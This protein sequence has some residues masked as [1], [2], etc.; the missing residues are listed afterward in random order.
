MIKKHDSA[1]TS[2]KFLLPFFL[3]GYSFLLFCIVWNHHSSYYYAVEDYFAPFFLIPL[4]SGL[5]LGATLVHKLSQRISAKKSYQ[6]LAILSLVIGLLGQFVPALLEQLNQSSRDEARAF[7]QLL[8]LSLCLTP[9]MLLYGAFVSIALRAIHGLPKIRQRSIQALSSASAGALIGV[10]SACWFLLPSF[11]LQSTLFIGGLGHVVAAGCFYFHQFKVSGDNAAT[12]SSPPISVAPPVILL[13]ALLSGLQLCS[14]AFVSSRLFQVHFGAAFPAQANLLLAVSLSL[15]IGSVIALFFLRK[16]PLKLL[17]GGQILGLFA[18]FFSLGKMFGMDQSLLALF[19]AATQN[20]D[21]VFPAQLKQSLYLSVPLLSPLA[22]TLPT[23]LRLSHSQGQSARVVVL[24]CLGGL[25]GL[26]LCSFYI[27]PSHSFVGAIYFVTVVTAL[28]AFLIAVTNKE[29][30]RFRIMAVVFSTAL[31]FW[32]MQSAKWDEKTLTRGYHSQSS[33]ERFD[34]ILVFKRVASQSIVTVEDNK[35]NNVRL[36]KSD[37]RILGMIPINPKQESGADISTDLTS[38]AFPVMFSAAPKRV[39]VIGVGTG[40][41]LGAMLTYEIETI[42]A[43]EQNAGVIAALKDEGELFALMNNRALEDKRLTLRRESPVPFLKSRPN[44]YD[45]I[46]YNP[47]HPWASRGS[48]LLTTDFYQEVKQAL[49]KDGI[50]GLPLSLENLDKDALKSQ[51]QTFLT[52]F[53]GAIAFNPPG[54]RVVLLLGGVKPLSVR[55]LELRLRSRGLKKARK[56]RNTFA[57]DI[58]SCFIAGP[59]FLKT[60]A[61]GAKGESLDGP[62]LVFRSPKLQHRTSADINAVLAELAE[63]SKELFDWL[64]DEA[65]VK[66]NQLHACAETRALRGSLEGARQLLKV[67][68]ERLSTL[69]ESQRGVIASQGHRLLGDLFFRSAKSLGAAEQQTYIKRSL[70]EWRKAIEFNPRAV[71]PRRSL[72]VYHLNRRDFD[73]AIEALEPG[74]TGKKKEDAAIHFV[75][76]R[77]YEAKK[78]YQLAWDAYKS[79]GTYGQARQ[80]AVCVRD[81]ADQGGHPIQ[82]PLGPRQKDIPLLVGAG[83][84]YLSQKNWKKAISVFKEVLSYEPEKLS[85]WYR[86]AY[87]YRGAKKFDTAISVVAKILLRKPPEMRAMKLRASL[88][89]EGGKAKESLKAWI[90]CAEKESGSFSSVNSLTASARL[91]IR[92]GQSRE[93]LKSLDRAAAIVPNHVLV[94]L[95]RGTA[96]AA[97]KEIEK[98]RAAYGKYLSIAPKTHP[99]RPTIERW[100]S[101]NRGQ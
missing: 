55:E 12:P 18:L 46:T 20:P 100:L 58:I 56:I 14:V 53:P 2:R 83:K 90:K 94:S 38:A 78:D 92:L 4:L 64:A 27:L 15:F 9:V 28:L 7:Q 61:A 65:V 47:D 85:H 72:A 5:S 60:F 45:I 25:I 52:V 17:L 68:F 88:L 21:S 32:F 36:L 30:R 87:A 54:T 84:R 11:G 79:A 62:A 6:L 71:A 50:F 70:V 97:L 22:W 77:I 23:L 1:L 82:L 93:A 16:S 51:L 24:Y 96:H 67:S 39:C 10:M 3:V 86:L 49:N 75:M 31:S 98:A 99:M 37:G 40:V 34:S 101:E 8:P 66:H 74:L 73:Q 33:P 26:T 63:G 48:M 19:Q 69:D 43:V 35:E 80:R 89:E 13:F 95:Y 59:Q 76:G 91:Q 57:K 44:A 42:D 29:K 81:L 41:R